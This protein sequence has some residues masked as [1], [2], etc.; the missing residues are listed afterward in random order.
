MEYK[1]GSPGGAIGG[2][3]DVLRQFALSRACTICSY[4][5]GCSDSPSAWLVRSNINVI[6]A[7]LRVCHPLHVY[8]A[9]VSLL[10]SLIVA[11]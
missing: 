4:V 7:K 3:I 5:Q 8:V 1:G 9:F 10:T 6:V 11:K 2:D